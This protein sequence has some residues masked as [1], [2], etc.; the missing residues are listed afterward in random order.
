M[1]SPIH[2]SPSPLKP[3]GHRPNG[4]VSRLGSHRHACRARSVRNLPEQSYHPPSDAKAKESPKALRYRLLESARGLTERESVRKCR[5]VR[6]SASGVEIRKRPNGQTYLAGLSTC[7]SVWECPVCAHGRKLVAA[8][9]LSSL[10]SLWLSADGSIYMATFTIRH[11]YSHD[12]D[13]TVRGVLDCW[14]RFQQ[15]A[16]YQRWRA[17]YGVEMVRSLEITHGKNGWHPHLHVLFLTTK[18]LPDRPDADGIL[19]ESCSWMYE[20][21]AQFVAEEMGEEHIPLPGVGTD[22]RVARKADYLAKMGIS[23]KALEITDA[24]AGKR[25]R[26][27]NR[28]P[29]QILEGAA[30]GNRRDC[31]IWAE[32]A[33]AMLGVRFL[34]WSHGLRDWRDEAE[35]AQEDAEGADHS[36]AEVLDVIEPE[37]WDRCRSVQGFTVAVLDAAASESEPA[38]RLVLGTYLDL[39]RE[40]SRACKPI[41]EQGIGWQT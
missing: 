22:L 41:C 14:K 20:R 23:G 31:A 36:E 35:R 39:A 25:G 30:A 18:P 17:R 8:A 11:G 37:V 21:W 10:E 12:L 26:K 4:S 2:R 6:I 27:G 28:T 7:D 9:A 13:M 24:Q 16:S 32:Y 15:G 40:I 5:R 33:R 19:L 29:W 1:L 38:I 34:G 3:S